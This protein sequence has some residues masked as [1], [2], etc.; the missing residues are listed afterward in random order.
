MS[1]YKQ[2]RR[3]SLSEHEVR[4]DIGL[5]DCEARTQLHEGYHPQM[6]P[7][8]GCPNGHLLYISGSHFPLTVSLPRN[9]DVKIVLTFLQENYPN[10]LKII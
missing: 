4:S 2:T 8:V 9:Y 10:P 1:L 7:Q 3:V 6:H 5:G